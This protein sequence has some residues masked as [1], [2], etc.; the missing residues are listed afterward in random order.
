MRYYKY[1]FAGIYFGIILVKSEVISWFRI[2]EMFRFQSFY[3]YGVIGSAVI[4]GM[5]SLFII[6][7]FRIKSLDGQTIYL[8]PKQFHKGQIFG[9]LIFGFGWALTGACPGPIFAQMGAGYSV[10]SVTFLAAVFGTWFYGFIRKSL[11]H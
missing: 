11:P 1:L 10:I 9:G 3:M 6:K 7:R 4:V 8:E 5:L 2:Q